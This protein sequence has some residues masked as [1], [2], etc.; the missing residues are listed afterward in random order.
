MRAAQ[1]M[2]SVGRLAGGVAHD[3]NNLLMV[4][5]NHVWFLRE[6]LKT[7]PL[8]VQDLE[9]IQEA[10]THATTLTRQLLTFSRPGGSQPVV[11]N[12]NTVIS[13]IARILRRLIGAD[14][15]LVLTL[16]PTAGHTKIDPSQLEQ[17]VMNLAVNAR[18][19]MPMGGR[20]EIVTTRESEGWIALT[21][22]DSG[23][24]MDAATQA[25]IFEPF[26]TTKDASKGTGLGLATLERIV[27]Q[28]EGT[29]EVSSV[30]GKGTRFVVRL[31]T[32]KD[33][34]LPQESVPAIAARP[35][36]E[37]TV[38]VVEDQELV[39]KTTVRILEGARFR[40]LQ[41]ARGEEAM[42]VAATLNGTKI[43]CVV[44]DVIMP[45]M[46]AVTMVQ[47]LS[48]KYPR[49]KVVFTSGYPGDVLESHGLSEK[50]VEYLAK[51]FTTSALLG[52]IRDVLDRSPPQ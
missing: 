6:S 41:A 21:V 18:D 12:V 34:A 11:V 24:G 28:A 46:S 25:R 17:V 39:R 43:D 10:T 47:R 29:V 7:M 2:E 23:T 30:L 49:L 32:T 33:L 26:F 13:G 42:Q 36:G 8:A 1:R 44:T 20:L 27:K 31:R 14:V 9:V 38:L 19:A 37:E 40:V 52:K 45:G 48:E 3:F 4:I 50:T 5:G 35:R 51:P 22:S 15:E 16:S